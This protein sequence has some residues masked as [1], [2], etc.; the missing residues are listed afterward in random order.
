MVS[1]VQALKLEIELPDLRLREANQALKLG[2]RP[3][4]LPK[5]EAK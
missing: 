2:T 4:D 5:G 1:G 3:S